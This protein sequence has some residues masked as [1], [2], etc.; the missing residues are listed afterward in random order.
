MNSTLS[1]Q[2]V[3]SAATPESISQAADYLRQGKLVAFATETVYG[4]GADATNDKAVAAIFAAKNR[5]DF[6]PLIAHV[7]DV[8]AAAQLVEMDQRAHT[9]AAKFW[10]GPL[11]LVLPDWTASR[12]GCRPTP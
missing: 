2:S 1:Q 7:A 9:L 5:P 11:T 8:D 6:N 12:C 3:I 4:L 10:P